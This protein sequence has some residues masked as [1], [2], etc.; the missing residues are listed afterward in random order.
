[1]IMLFTPSLSDYVC[2]STSVSYFHLYGRTV[3][4]LTYYL[5]FD[6]L[7]LLLW[8]SLTQLLIPKLVTLPVHELLAIYSIILTEIAK[9]LGLAA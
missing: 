1:M 9:I 2:S 4:W 3:A 7:G 6:N 5:D 8:D